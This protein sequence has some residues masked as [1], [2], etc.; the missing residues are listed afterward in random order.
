MIDHL[1]GSDTNESFTPVM[2]KLI[3]AKE[4]SGFRWE[5]KLLAKRHIFITFEP[6]SRKLSAIS[7]CIACVS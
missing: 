6:F 7:S 3:G 5:I 1:A 4:L 2:D